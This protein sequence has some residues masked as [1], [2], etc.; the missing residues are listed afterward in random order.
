MEEGRQWR[1]GRRK[2]KEVVY[3]KLVSCKYFEN[4]IITPE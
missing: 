2:G 3:R 1:R 4:I